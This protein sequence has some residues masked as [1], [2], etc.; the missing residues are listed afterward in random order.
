MIALR[1]RNTWSVD[2]NRL[3]WQDDIGLKPTSEEIE[4]K[5]QEAVIKVIGVG[6]CGNNAVD[7]MIEKNVHG[8]DFI[9]VNTDLQSLKKS[10]ANNI[11]Q[12]GLNH[13][14]LDFW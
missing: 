7:F 5:K 13:N 8:V 11:V 10:Q 6:G 4:Q 14:L 9:S 3:I 2:G 12:I 1:P